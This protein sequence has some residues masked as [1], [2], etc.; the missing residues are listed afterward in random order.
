MTRGDKY[1]SALELIRHEEEGKDYTIEYKDRNSPTLII[2]PHGK[3][4]ESACFKITKAIAAGDLSYYV[5]SAGQPG[6]RLHVTSTRFDEP[7]ALALVA[8]SDTVVAVH[9]MR[10]ADDRPQIIVGGRDTE[11]GR[12]LS[13][14]LT[15]Y[16]FTAEIR[17]TGSLSG[18]APSNICNRGKKNAGVQLEISRSLR[19]RLE[20]EP[21]LLRS[22]VSAIRLGLKV[23]PTKL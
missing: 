10:D 7:I 16:G 3:G 6:T 15:W 20:Y 1:G 21:M 11:L 5:F 19:D 2:A 13:D 9:G 18:N 22:F 23:L 4:I 12:K 14:N 17:T 8:K